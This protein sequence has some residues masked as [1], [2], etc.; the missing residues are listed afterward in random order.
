M[1]QYSKIILL[2]LLL[3]IFNLSCYK[4]TD[5]EAEK[6]VLDLS[7]K[8]I[9]DL[10]IV[11][12]VGQWE[13]YWAQLLEPSDFETDLPSIPL[14]AKVP[15]SWED[16]LTSGVNTSA[17]GFATY[18]L[19]VKTSKQDSVYG[20]KINRI[21]AS[22]RL[23]VNGKLISSAG[24]VAKV[25]QE[26]T[27]KWSRK[28]KIV[29]TSEQDLEIIVQVSN[30]DFERGGITNAMQLSSDEYLK[31]KI[32]AET[33]LD[34][35]LLGIML[36][37]AIYHLVLFLLRRSVISSLYFSVLSI[38]ASALVLIAKDYNLIY[39]FWPE[40][41]WTTH[42]KTEYTF[43]FLSL[44]FLVLFIASLFKQ[45]ADK[46]IV[47][48]IVW[49]SIFMCLFVAV[50]PVSFFMVIFGLLEW[51]FI[52]IVVYLLYV[53]FKAQVNKKE[54]SRQS[55]LGLLLLTLAIIHDVIIDKYSLHGITLLPFGF[56]GF[57]LIQ[58][59]I[60]SSRFVE[61]ISYSEQLTEEMDFMNNN[62]EQLVKERTT[63]VEQQKEELLM[64]SESL[65]V[66]ND[67]IVKINHI[68]EQQSGEMNKKNK[69]LTDSLNYAKRLQSAVLPDPNYLKEVLPEHFIFFLPKDIVSG[70]FYWYG[71]V[72]SSWDFDDASSIQV[73][74]AADCTGHGVPGAFMTLL[75]NNFLNVTVNTQEVTDPEQIIYKVDQQVVETLRQN[76]P[77]SIKDGMDM[78]V[79]SIEQDK[80]LI[81][82]AGAGSPLYYFS[83]GEFEEIKGANFGIGGVLR[84]EKIF[85][86]HKV[87][88]QSGDVF[89]IFSDGFADQ[90]GGKEGRKFYKKRFKEFL[91]EI[92]DKPMEEQY[93]LIERKYFEWKSDFKQIDDILVIGLRMP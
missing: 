12:L 43:Y 7:Q 24:K 25:K 16:I 69:A 10:G 82:F 89:Y 20:I 63:K 71:E 39:L 87:E 62:L 13:F 86:P 67:E 26:Y 15:G 1:N 30:F 59:Y 38:F 88:Y 33:G 72:D 64:Q 58:A 4:E 68:L 76:D 17:K 57:M 5:Y 19:I 29:N 53:V 42:L 27:P 18:R 49:F 54:G 21:D 85:E 92:H 83:N 66:A 6:G 61:A 22:Y 91:A 77:N 55:I 78:A 40:I 75:G 11:D 50:A 65:K 48:I 28:E 45:E 8:S 9:N 74:I 84:K 44:L 37:I 31:N 46:T 52:V 23:W 90:I 80:N 14:Y 41:N 34:F 3:G 73:L 93:K 2:I 56:L 51:I 60:I 47:K 81:S 36:I 70:D 35:F 32:K 79:L